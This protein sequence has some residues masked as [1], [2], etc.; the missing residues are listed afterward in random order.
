MKWNPG[1][2]LLLAAASAVV[3]AG[4]ALGLVFAQE[5]W[6]GHPL[7]PRFVGG[8]GGGPAF[9]PS[10]GP[11]PPGVQA[12][13]NYTRYDYFLLSL[14]LRP[15]D[16]VRIERN[17]LPLELYVYDSRQLPTGLSMPLWP[18]EAYA[19]G[20]PGQA[21]EVHRSSPPTQDV[22]WPADTQ[23]ADGL[24]MFWIGTLPGN[25]TRYSWSERL[26]SVAGF[27]SNPGLY[28]VTRH[29]YSA[30]FPW[31]VSASCA[32]LV[33]MAS[34]GWAWRRSRRPAATQS[35]VAS[36]LLGSVETYLRRLNA[37]MWL[38]G[39]L[40]AAFGI[41]AGL[42]LYGKLAALP[43]PDPNRRFLPVFLFVVTILG[44]LLA[45]ALDM[46]R[47]QRERRRLLVLRDTQEP[48]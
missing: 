17:P 4:G 8:G 12:E 37:Y 34:F 36:D 19:H 6:V 41:L 13:E 21:V 30:A 7:Q 40:F 28:T 29:E 38:A 39:V 18:M 35:P 20:R 1:F 48:H 5:A 25:V 26:D 2:F 11:L 3:A 47:V 43:S 22:S 10:T 44:A 9:D 45:W 31:L 27:A 15:H 24:V 23:N 33:A 14:P 46:R 32:G 42:D 16:S